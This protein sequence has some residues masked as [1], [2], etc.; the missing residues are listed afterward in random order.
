MPRLRCPAPLRGLGV[1]LQIDVS[2]LEE[3]SLRTVV[4][5]T[6]QVLFPWIRARR[7]LIRACTSC[8][9]SIAEKGFCRNR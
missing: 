7:S 8:T 2:R 3:E 1:V 4:G 6:G 9:R 5:V